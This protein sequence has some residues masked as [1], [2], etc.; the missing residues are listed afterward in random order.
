MK[1]K[2]E[3]NEL[4]RL[5]DQLVRDTDAASKEACESEKADERT[6]KAF[7]NLQKS[8]LLAKRADLGAKISTKIVRNSRKEGEKK[9]R[10]A[11]LIR[12]HKVLNA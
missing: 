1:L 3:L 6:S 7:L 8:Q 11:A 2:D 12:I 10:E 9:F 4:T 5:R